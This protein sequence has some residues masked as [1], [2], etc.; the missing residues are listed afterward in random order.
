[1]MSDR[2]SSNSTLAIATPRGH[3]ASDS[4]SL[5][6]V[7]AATKEM[8]RYAEMKVK[9]RQ[10]T[11]SADGSDFEEASRSALPTLPGVRWDTKLPIYVL[12]HY[13][14][15]EKQV[16]STL[17]S[18]GGYGGNHA[19]PSEAESIYLHRALIVQRKDRKSRPAKKE[20]S[21]VPRS[22]P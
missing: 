13:M 18:H 22:V 1:M 6:G 19:Y 21:E 9:E 20:I 2:C 15:R 14:S 11:A 12:S 8:I 3:D 10:R 4:H 5:Q 17:K 7:Y 16:C